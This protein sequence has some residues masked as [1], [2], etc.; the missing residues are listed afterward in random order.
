MEKQTKNTSVF[1]YFQ[2]GCTSLMVAA[3]SGDRECV[4]LLLKAGAAVNASHNLVSSLSLLRIF[5]FLSIFSVSV[6]LA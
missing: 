2:Y 5:L 6:H 1:V 3:K 4:S